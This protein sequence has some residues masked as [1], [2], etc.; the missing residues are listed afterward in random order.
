[1][2]TLEYFNPFCQH[3][4]K[5]ITGII[6]VG[7]HDYEER[8]TY[9]ELFEQSDD[10]I[11]WIDAVPSSINAR[12]TIQAC[13]SNTTGPATLYVSNYSQCTGLL[14]FSTE[15]KEA[16]KNISQTPVE[17]ETTT[18]DLL[19]PKADRPLKNTLVVSVNGA[20]L[21]VLKGAETLLEF[22][23]FVFVRFEKLKFHDNVPS[24][25]ELQNWMGVNGFTYTTSVPANQ[26]TEMMLFISLDVQEV[27][28]QKDKEMSDM[29]QL[30][31]EDYNN[32]NGTGITTEVYQD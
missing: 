11:L 18:L 26:H 15:H 4:T 29:F 32:K 31:V 17:V 1:M 30:M 27:N 25:Y 28:R 2:K 21:Q 20:E 6:H 8:D 9:L 24:F 3:I 13:C 19:I 7:A 16:F 10:D 23:D 22:I 12:K 5:V 14:P